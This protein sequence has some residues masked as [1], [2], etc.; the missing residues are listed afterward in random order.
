M[1]EPRLAALLLATPLICIAAQTGVPMPTRRRSGRSGDQEDFR[2]D[3][4]RSVE[5]R[6]STAAPS[7]GISR[8][9]PQH[10]TTHASTG[11]DRTMRVG[12]DLP[13]ID[14]RAAYS[15]TWNSYRPA[16]IIHSP[17]QRRDPDAADIVIRI[18]ISVAPAPGTRRR[19]QWRWRWSVGRPRATHCREAGDPEG[20]VTGLITRSGPGRK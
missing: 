18:S 13:P 20:M 10:S 3:R 2:K 15:A 12:E 5:A 8:D 17:L 9:G 11:S 19:S 7:P 6:Q 4:Q 16:W 1:H 14:H